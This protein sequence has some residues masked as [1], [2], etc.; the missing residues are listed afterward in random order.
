[1]F[2]CVCAYMMCTHAH[3]H[4]YKVNCNRKQTSARTLSLPITLHYTCYSALYYIILYHIILYQSIL[5]YITLHYITLHYTTLRYATLHYITLQHFL[6][7]Y[8]ILHYIISYILPHAYHADDLAAGP[9]ARRG[10]QED[11]APRIRPVSPT[12]YVGNGC[13]APRGASKTRGE[14]ATP[15]P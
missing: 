10:V 12:K 15:A 3:M 4:L 6:L 13:R 7:Y 9:S 5:H 11:F 1:M 2:A 14:I 8:I